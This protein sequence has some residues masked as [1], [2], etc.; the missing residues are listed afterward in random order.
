[1]LQHAVTDVEAVVILAG[2]KGL[3][4]AAATLQTF[5]GQRIGIAKPV[6]FRQTAPPIITVKTAAR[7]DDVDVGRAPAGR[8]V[9]LQVSRKLTK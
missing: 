6:H 2:G 4:P 8:P 5:A 3:D 1:M 7:P 9:H